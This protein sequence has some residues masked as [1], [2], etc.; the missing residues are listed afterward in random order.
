MTTEVSTRE[1]E[2]SHGKKPR[3]KGPWAFFFDRME[4]PFFVSGSYTHAKKVAILF[5]K[6]NGYQRIEV[7]S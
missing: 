7:G 2:F 5:A 4:E 1:Y 6:I 3:G